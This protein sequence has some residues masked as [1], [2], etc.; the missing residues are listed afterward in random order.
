[1]L[2][3]AGTAMSRSSFSV[4]FVHSR[5]ATIALC[6]RMGGGRGTRELK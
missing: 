1:M 2:P 4:L 5:I 6:G 3:S